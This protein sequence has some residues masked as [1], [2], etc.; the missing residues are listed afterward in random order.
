MGRLLH[1]QALVY[2]QV[3]FIS[4]TVRQSMPISA[5]SLKLFVNNQIL[6][7]TLEDGTTVVD[8][9]ISSTKVYYNEISGH[10][11]FNSIR[12][13]PDRIGFWRLVFNS[14]LIEVIK[15]YDIIGAKAATSGLNASFYG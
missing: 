7:W 2:D 15:E 5:L 1:A 12:F 10:S 13:Y 14:P 4:G 11:G 3:D 9:S 8:S 6:P